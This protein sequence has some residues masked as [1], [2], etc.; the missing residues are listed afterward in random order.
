[1]ADISGHIAVYRKEEEGNASVAE[2][3]KGERREG[4][5]ARE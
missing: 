2:G 4:A 1:M 3:S 5:R